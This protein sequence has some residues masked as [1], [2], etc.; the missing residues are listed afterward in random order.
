MKPLQPTHYCYGLI[1]GWYLKTVDFFHR[2]CWAISMPSK[3]ELLLHPFLF[4]MHK[5]S[6]RG[7][8]EI[9]LRDAIMIYCKLC[10]VN[11]YYLAY[12]WQTVQLYCT[13]LKLLIREREDRLQIKSTHKATLLTSFN[14]LCH[15]WLKLISYTVHI[16]P[17]EM[18]GIIRASPWHHELLTTEL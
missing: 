6:A 7:L 15:W 5:I 8:C 3:T 16:N 9:I 10:P 18:N 17:G 1:T 12:L 14:N 4:V 13:I 2:N 11:T